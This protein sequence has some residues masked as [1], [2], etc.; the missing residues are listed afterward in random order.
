MRL[1]DSSQHQRRYHTDAA[2]RSQ[3]GRAADQACAATTLAARV[4]QAE[5]A[6]SV[7]DADPSSAANEAAHALAPPARAPVPLD[8]QRAAREGARGSE[9]QRRVS[10]T[11][12]AAS[13]ATPAQA[14]TGTA[15][16]GL[17]SALASPTRA[18]GVVGPVGG[19]AASVDH[20]QAMADA[21][22]IVGSNDI[23][24]MRQLAQRAQAGDA[25]AVATL[26]AVANMAANGGVGPAG[27]FIPD[28]ATL[29][30]L[31]RE[32]LS[33]IGNAAPQAVGADG[34]AALA[35]AT[36]EEDAIGNTPRVALQTLAA[37]G[38]PHALDHARS[39]VT[40]P[41]GGGAAGAGAAQSAER[42]FAA[43]LLASSPP[44]SLTPQDLAALRPFA[45]GS[46][47]VRQRLAQEDGPTATFEGARD[48]LH[49]GNATSADLRNL[50]DNP[51]QVAATDLPHL[52]AAA[53]SSS[54]DVGEQAASALRAAARR[55]PPLDGA[56]AALLALADDVAGNTGGVAS[57][58][59][60]E[61]FQQTRDT[62]VERSLAH[63][64]ASM[65]PVDSATLARA[66]PHLAARARDGDMPATQALARLVSRANPRGFIGRDD[67]LAIRNGG[68]YRAAIDA[69]AAAG[70]RADAT[71]AQRDAAR[72][73]L[74]AAMNESPG[75]TNTAA[76]RGLGAMA[77]AGDVGATEALARRMRNI[78]GGAD[79]LDRMQI[80]MGLS[81]VGA[82]VRDANDPRVPH[83]LEIARLGVGNQQDLHSTGLTAASEGARLMQQLPAAALTQA[84]RELLQRATREGWCPATR[85]AGAQAL[86]QS[87]ATAT[88]T[89]RRAALRDIVRDATQ[90]DEYHSRTLAREVLRQAA[91][92]L[93]SQSIADMA[94]RN[95]P[96]L[97]GILA[98]SLRQSSAAPG[99][100]GNGAPP[101]AEQRAI[102]EHLTTASSVPPN[103]TS[104]AERLR[105]LPAAERQAMAALVGRQGDAAM[106][107]HFARATEGLSPSDV[108]AFARGALA[109]A[110]PRRADNA[111]FLLDNRFEHVPGEAREALFDIA[112]SQPD[113]A[114]GHAFRLDVRERFPGAAVP[115]TDAQAR[116][117]MTRER[118]ER[119]LANPATFGA[120][121]EAAGGR[122]DGTLTRAELQRISDGTVPGVSPDLRAAADHMLHNATLPL[123]SHALVG[124]TPRSTFHYGF[125][126]QRH[127]LTISRRSESRPGMPPQ[128]TLTV[129]DRPA[130][131]PGFTRDH[132]RDSGS[133]AWHQREQGYTSN[134]SSTA[135]SG[136][137]ARADVVMGRR[138][139]DTTAVHPVTSDIEGWA[140]AHAV[141]GTWA[142]QHLRNR[143]DTLAGPRGHVGQERIVITDE[144]V[145]RGHT[146]VQSTDR[147][148]A[149]SAPPASQRVGELT[150]TTFR[151]H[152]NGG[153]ESE[154]QWNFR[155]QTAD[156]R[157]DSQMFL[158][159]SNDTVFTR[160]TTEG[161]WRVTTNEARLS[162]AAER[163]RAGGASAAN[164]PPAHQ[165][166]TDLSA[167]N[168][169][170]AQ[171]T[172]MMRDGRVGLSDMTDSRAMQEFLARAG[173][174]ANISVS[175]S[176]ERAGASAD[177]ARGPSTM[178]A[179]LPDGSRVTMRMEATGNA[180]AEYR[181]GGDAS[182]K[183]LS[184]RSEVGAT[185]DVRLRLDEATQ[186][187]Q[188]SRFVDG[189]EQP[190]VALSAEVSAARALAACSRYGEQMIS[191]S[192]LLARAAMD[193]G[194]RGLAGF[195][196]E[197]NNRWA[198]TTGVSPAVAGRIDS[199]FANADA[200]MTRW[201][202][203]AGNLHATMANRLRP[204]M[205]AANAAVG[206]MSLANL[207]SMRDAWAAG[208]GVG[209]ANAAAN[210]V[211]DSGSAV[212]GLAEAI[213]GARTPSA[214]L[215]A[216]ITAGR[217]CNGVGA[218]A[219]IGMGVYQ[220]ANGDYVRGGFSIGAG[221]GC[222]MAL[223]GSIWASVGWM[224]PVGAG[225]AIVCTIGSLGY[226]HTEG[227]RIAPPQIPV[228]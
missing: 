217:V 179:T 219:G 82:T 18:V 198:S 125:D 185:E 161:P 47:A 111:R 220:M 11:D 130:G 200:A 6:A 50:A 191:Q 178:I 128:T 108:N 46:E 15:T 90:Q 31:R 72:A 216:V 142:P 204:V 96:E 154:A 168:I 206:V 225:I 196:R 182:Q 77:T 78:G 60:V 94:A 183:I 30:N 29:S 53:R 228:N 175:I 74:V 98:S 143:L 148:F 174:N 80:L 213:N 114:A 88:P 69:L 93:D 171:L 208:D 144:D 3:A 155:R 17:A 101:T 44:G 106:R 76:A 112:R 73:A 49:A 13:Q 170:G 8:L 224:G 95:D 38:N 124:D 25:T 81:G 117:G 71:P 188:V 41:A 1:D 169:T 24:A 61:Q 207:A 87:L 7:D 97:D 107:A 59:A 33:A 34:V 104:A 57:Q 197:W 135:T 152:A 37:G 26:V 218:A 167:D 67:G 184:L 83:L 121:K 192:P 52:V 43:E 86:I 205:G 115:L 199:A 131:T 212:G 189:R 62:A 145:L 227:T 79:A 165:R 84:D 120:L 211:A 27:G 163:A 133:R 12:R 226:D 193:L 19:A 105:R 21:G 180:A 91:P 4:R 116:A 137:N 42:A 2:Q 164:V 172:A 129:E 89:E 181:P 160:N 201:Q 39:L 85:R 173:G 122:R 136:P 40:N 5:D 209:V 45:A 127:D 10:L 139:T 75:A 186:Q 138:T 48:R 51:A 223:A 159:G 141:R 187:V 210:F 151:P 126:G 177:A 166:L 110:N 32:A 203:Q 132:F 113:S 202:Q 140:P 102:V 64:V 215:R 118:A 68:H 214:G 100:P 16:R 149:Q 66:M 134:M 14:P 35:D 123:S 195:R 99:A 156:G 158:Q 146:D 221:V 194:Q 58:F 54:A 157:V 92:H 65:S 9:L 36:R 103:T 150:R 153:R 109:P 176:A 20:Q 162:E 55:D 119:M 23:A 222:G 22:R 70:S 190:D 147:F 28:P 63:H 56:A